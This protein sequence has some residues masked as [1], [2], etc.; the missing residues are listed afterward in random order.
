MY[1]HFPCHSLGV[2][3]VVQFL[4]LCNASFRQNFPN[5]FVEISEN[6]LICVNCNGDEVL[7]V[8]SSCSY[9]KKN[10]LK[11]HKMVKR[12]KLN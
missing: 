11:S 7:R 2:A 4:L 3:G 12:L 6:I 1:Q 9:Y 8:F 5:Q 10:E